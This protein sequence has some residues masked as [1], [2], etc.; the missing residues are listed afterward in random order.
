MPAIRRGPL[1]HRQARR[2]QVPL[3]RLVRHHRWRVVLVPIVGLLALTGLNS[4]R[5][6]EVVLR[7][8]GDV[9]QV[10]VATTDLPAGR[11]LGEQDLEIIGL[12]GGAVPSGA[13]PDK[14]SPGDDPRPHLVGKTVTQSVLRGELVSVRRLAPLGLGPTAA[15]VP[16]GHRAFAVPTTG[17]IP[18]LEVGDRIDLLASVDPLTAATV[19][20]PGARDTGVH[21]VARDVAVLDIGPN[22]LTVVV[23][24]SQLPALV[25][26]AA[27][28]VLMPA[29]AGN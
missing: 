5:N 29:L 6:A 10:A 28:S 9:V 25:A 1:R 15:L 7:Q 8:W 19:G 22:A 20:L 2:R 14:T 4:T 26:A 12:P 16:V 23:P 18:P 21:T 13:L 17:A 11:V 3:R 24:A 27:R